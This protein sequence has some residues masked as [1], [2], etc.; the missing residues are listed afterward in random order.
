[1]DFF[2]VI[3]GA[4]LYMLEYRKALFQALIIPFALTFVVNML[5]GPGLGGGVQLLLGVITLMLYTIIAV[6]AHRILL[7]GPGAVPRWGFAKWT[8]RETRFA[9]RFFLL[10]FGV[11]VLIMLL[12]IP[13]LSCPIIFNHK[14]I[15]I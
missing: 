15:L 6:N 14:G 5:Q 13:F 2:K 3:A 9:L 11:T 12:A 8:Q 7:L 4:S 1:M 10:I